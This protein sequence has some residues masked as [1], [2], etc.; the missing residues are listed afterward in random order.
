[1]LTRAVMD[2]AGVHSFVHHSSRSPIL[3]VPCLQERS[4]LSDGAKDAADAIK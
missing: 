3:S 4:Y 2:T 1:M